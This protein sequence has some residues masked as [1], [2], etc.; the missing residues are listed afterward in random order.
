MSGDFRVGRKGQSRAA[1]AVTIASAVFAWSAGA[2][3]FDVKKAPGGVDVRWYD[4]NVTYHLDSSVSASTSGAADAITAAAQSWSGLEGAPSLTVVQGGGGASPG[5][6]GLNTIFYAPKGSAL[7]GGALAVTV[8]TYDSNGHA[9]DVDVIINGR[10]SFSV[11][12]AGAVAAAGVQPVS[13]EG[14]SLEPCS[15]PF[16]LHHVLAHELGHT[17]GMADET[18]DSSA[19]M[20]LYTAPGAA[21]PRAP[22]SDDA[23]GIASLYDTTTTVPA[24]GGCSGSTVSPRSPSHQASRVALMIGLGLVAWVVSRRRA[25]S[26]GKS[27]ALGA[28]LFAAFMALPSEHAARPASRLVTSSARAHVTHTGT[29]VDASGIFM[30]RATL[31]TTECRVARCPSDT[32]VT[33]YG[34]IMGDVHQEVGGAIAPREG[35]DVEIALDDA[36]SA[37]IVSR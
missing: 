4:A 22:E 36:L 2:Q 28:A 1:A 14:A 3:A 12:P 16:D 37:R 33:T 15:A 34:G 7:T 29:T 21:S 6:D 23:A 5:Y 26:L 9:L 24:A 30:T 25:G 17:L 27:V 35:D 8:F 31:T 20:F 11:L 32:V 19:L 10:Y 18:V 13:T